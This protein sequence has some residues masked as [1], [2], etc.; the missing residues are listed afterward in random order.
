L[1]R[2]SR[3][4]RY[5][6]ATASGDDAFPYVYCVDTSTGNPYYLWQESLDTTGSAIYGTPLVQEAARARALASRG[7]ARPVLG[8]RNPFLV[9]CPW[10]PLV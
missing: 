10:I 6:A 4:A 9:S 5:V 1:S 7:V 3:C 2:A 8:T